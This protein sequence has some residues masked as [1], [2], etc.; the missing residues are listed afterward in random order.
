MRIHDHIV[1]ALRYM[2]LAV[3]HGLQVPQIAHIRSE[4]A[5]IVVTIENEDP[6][7]LMDFT[8][9]LNGLAREHEARIRA[10]RPGVDVDE[11][12]LLIVEVRKGSIVLEM[13]PALAPIVTTLE[14]TNTAVS[15]VN[16]IGTILGKLSIPGGRVEDA[17]TNQLKNMTDAVQS[18]VRDSNGSL[19]VEA[20]YQNGDVLQEF[21]VTRDEAVAIERNSIEQRRELEQTK[22]VSYPSVLLRLHQSSVEDLKIGKKTSEKGIVE[23]IDLRPRSLIYASDLAGQRI[24]DEILKPDGNPYS[25]VFVVDLNV[26]TVGGRP[27]AYRIM[28]VV[29]VLDTDDD[30]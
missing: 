22:D 8:A 24:K 28:N 29:D 5:Y 21:I 17:T 19:K 15:F 2:I 14:F 11:T 1:N 27:R 18:V 7:D 13:L 10:E 23:A 4:A 16:H 3:R 25:K 6:V 9:S 20:K 30:D 12:R 26:E